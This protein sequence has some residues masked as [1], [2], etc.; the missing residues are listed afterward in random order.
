[1]VRKNRK[2]GIKTKSSRKYHREYWRKFR[3]GQP[4]HKRSGGRRR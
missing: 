1:M 4:G 3:A 2:T